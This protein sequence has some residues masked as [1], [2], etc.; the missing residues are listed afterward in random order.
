[1]VLFVNGVLIEEP[2]PIDT[3]TLFHNYPQLKDGAA[4]LL[5]IQTKVIGTVGVLY[6]NQRE[7]AATVPHD[8][9]V[10]ILGTDDVTTCCAVVVRHRTSGAV[11]LGHFDGSS[12]DDGISG[13]IG[14]VQ[15][16][17]LGYPESRLE[18][19]LVGSYSDPRGYSEELASV[20]LHA[21]HKNPLELD[22]VQCCIC[23][24]NT[25]LRGN[26]RW[27]IAYGIGVN[28]KTGDIFPANFPEKGPDMPLRN[29]RHFTGSH[30]ML[31]IYDCNLGLM[32]IGP[33]HYEPLRGVDLWLQ[34]TDDFILKHLSTAPEV[35]PNH[36]VLQARASLKHIREHPFPAVT[37]F[38]DNRPRYFRR[39]ENGLWVHVRY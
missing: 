5:A 39:D 24:L 1:M 6:V 21:L 23:E 11:A 31:D 36:F 16:L 29:A 38:P 19:S 32:K 3:R 33:F 15:E 20:I 27:P 37:V 13:M 30:E 12:V 22:L 17:S 4:Q 2:L 7:F 34:Q 35:E 25:S 10:N 28:T 9:N 18:L 8:K 26:C 14:R